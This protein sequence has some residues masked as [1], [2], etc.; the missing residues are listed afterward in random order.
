MNQILLTT[1]ILIILIFLFTLLIIFKSSKYE[2]FSDNNDTEDET[3][4]EDRNQNILE[5]IKTLNDNIKELNTE[6]DDLQKNLIPKAN[7]KIKD[8]EDK[9]RTSK[10]VYN[11]SIEG[12]IQKYIINIQQSQVKCLEDKKTLDDE[13]MY[14][15]SQIGEL[16]M[17]IMNITNDLPN[18]KNDLDRV[19]K[20]YDDVNQQYKAKC[21][22]DTSYGQIRV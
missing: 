1:L 3:N 10:K 20:E 22:T 6:I 8:N 7:K 11:D 15:K 4:I 17:K 12:A 21:P 18:K 9:L 19:T 5:K 13:V 2:Y 16:N 14:N